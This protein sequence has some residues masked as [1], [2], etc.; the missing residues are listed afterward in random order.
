MPHWG[1]LVL[2]FAITA[3]IQLI[4]DGSSIGMALVHGVAAISFTVVLFRLW[5]WRKKLHEP[6]A[7]PDKRSDDIAV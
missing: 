7:T 5:A 4:R 1:S 6:K 3:T 2:V